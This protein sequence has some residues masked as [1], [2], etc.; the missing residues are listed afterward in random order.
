MCGIAGMLGF[1]TGSRVDEQT[2]ERMSDTLV[3]RGPDDAGAL[4]RRRTSASPRPPA[5]VDHRPVAAGHQPMSN[6]DGSVWITYNGEVYNHEALRARA[7][8]ARAT[9]TARG[10]TP[11]RSSTSTRRRGRAA[12]SGSRACS[13]SRSGTRDG[14]ELFLAR[15]RV[16]VKPLYYAQLPGGFVFG[17]EI[18]AIL[19][20]PR[21]RRDARRGGVLRLP[22]VR[23]HATAADDVRGDLEARARR[24]DDRRRRRAPS[25]ATAGGTRSPS[26]DGGPSPRSA[27][28]RWSTSCGDC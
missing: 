26:A 3:H 28:R 12:S 14:R 15:D 19:E 4:V 20:H 24:A 23:L 27:S 9:A 21:F 13:P 10:P 16:G 25:S 2:V 18:K 17:S 6:E 22:H 7:R 1:T 11:R 8:G 5:A